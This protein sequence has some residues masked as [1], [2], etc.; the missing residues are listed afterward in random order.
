MVIKPRITGLMLA[1][2]ALLYMPPGMGAFAD[3]DRD[4]LVV[5]HGSVQLEEVSLPMLREIILGQRRFWPS[6]ERVELVV[7]ATPGPARSTFVEWLS[8]MTEAQFQHYW[9]SLIFSHRATRPPRAAPD[10]RLALALVN[11]IPGALTLVEEGSLPENVRVLRV[12]G[13]TAES[14]GYPLP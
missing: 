14:D 1:L 13:L 6:G 5:V 4:I 12:D 7:E 11:A 10:R 2:F 9:T 8:G 3:D